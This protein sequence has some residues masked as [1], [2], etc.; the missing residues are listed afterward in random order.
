MPKAMQLTGQWYV[1]LLYYA[2]K[3]RKQG[4]KYVV[5]FDSNILNR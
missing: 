2:P 1:C 4:I 5:V 3:E